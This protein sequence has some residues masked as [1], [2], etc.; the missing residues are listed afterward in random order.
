MSDE[1][2][3]SIKQSFDLTDHQMTESGILPIHP[4]FRIIAIGEPPSLN[5]PTGNWMTPELLSLF[6]FHEVR[7]LSKEEELHIIASKVSGTLCI[8]TINRLCF[9]MDHPPSRC[10]KS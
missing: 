8:R 1:R 4:D 6:L 10:S 3:Q 2:Y 9:S 5:S 7:T